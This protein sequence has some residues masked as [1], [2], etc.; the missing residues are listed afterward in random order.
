MKIII[1]TLTLFIFL[2][3]SAQHLSAEDRQNFNPRFEVFELPGDIFGNSVQGM[4]QDKTGFLWFATQAGLHRYD[5]QNFVTYRHDG[6][7]PNSLSADYI[8]SIFL[9]SKGV[10][11]LTHWQSGALTAFDPER[12]I[13][14]RYQHNPDDPGSLSG[15]VLSTVAEDHEGYIWIGGEL[16][17]NRYDPETG[18]F[19]RFQYDPENPK[20]LSYNRVRALYV[21]KTGTLWVGTGFPWD[22]DSSKGGLNRYN[23]E[24]GTFTRYLHDPED[25]TT[26]INNKVRAILEDSRGNFWVGTAGDGLHLMDREKGTF[27]RLTS[28]PLNPDKISGPW[29]PGPTPALTDSTTHITSIFEDGEGRIWIT[30]FPGGLKIFDPVSGIIRHF[31][32][33]S[34][35]D[36]LSTDF[37]WLTYQTSDGTLWIT[38][39][40]DGQTVFKV[41]QYDELFPFFD[42]PLSEDNV[43]S[44]G[45]VKDRAGNIWIARDAFIEHID[46]VTGSRKVITPGKPQQPAS[47]IFGLILDREGY[48]WAGTF[49]GQFCGDPETSDFQL[50]KPPGISDEI[51]Q[52][53]WSPFLHSSSGHFWFGSW[54]NGLFRYDPVTDEV[55]NYA[56]DPNDP[57]SLGGM[58]VGSIYEDEKGNIWVGGGSPHGD[59]S[60]PLFLDRINLQS[61]RIERFFDANKQAGMVSDITEDNDGNLWFIDWLHGFKMLNPATGI[62]KSFT[63]YNSLL[64]SNYLLSL[65]NSGDG[66]LWLSDQS[67]IIEFDPATEIMSVFNQNRGIRNAWDHFKSGFVADDGEVFFS[68]RGGFHAF[69]PD[70]ILQQRNTSLP[71]IRITGFQMLGDQNPSAAFEL[72][73]KP[74]WQTTAVRLAHDQNLFT[75]SVACFD[76]Y[77]ASSN[78]LQF[79]LEGYDKAWRN[80]IRDGETSPYINVP[81]G[82]YTFRVRG[83]NSF[84]VWNMEGASLGITILPPWWKSWWAYAFYLLVLI[85]GIWWIHKYQKERT[86]RKEREKSRDR[87]LEQARKIEKAYTELKTTQAQLIQAEK[88]ASLGELTA[89]IAHEI[90][91]PLNFVNNFS[92][93]NAELLQELKEELDN[94]NLEEVKAITDDLTENEGKIN[95]HGKRADAI[96]KGMLQHSCASA[97]QKEP[98]DINALADEYLRLSYH[99]LRAKDKSFNADFKTEF[100]PNLLKVEVIPQDIGRVLLNL[101]NNAFYAVSEKQKTLTGLK[102]DFKPTVTITTKNLGDRIEISV[103]DNGPGIPDEIKNKIFQPFFT[104][105]KGTEGTGL[106][107]SI[108]HDIVKAH[109]GNLNIKSKVG[110]GTEFIVIIPL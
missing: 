88:M 77:D 103:K 15:S 90:Q 26:L 95:H 79:M 66:K 62:F 67:S 50:F 93:L 20:S 58:M 87:E 54:E 105:K 92:E 86:I 9:D 72:F 85:F 8:E 52:A 5:G 74:V 91:N 82:D 39:G 47:R 84:G 35:A 29:Q 3:L 49:G 4:V 7:N 65:V 81:P 28:N 60:N 107:L 46:R 71:D 6:N 110:E 104:T 48:L 83:A 10:L 57:N 59:I 18:T 27:K 56:H 94:G 11:W 22:T 16:G 97:G 41:K 14:N 102:D 96:V 101:I 30:A 69:Y 98:T 68:R 13:F 75:L 33:G 23:P 100:D 42:I 36:E 108:T 73:E 38:S 64:P 34:S 89:G 109:G 21:D 80:D 43:R 76:F 99:G 45:I 24:D 78:Q 63:P 17:L 70:Q 1:A 32:M 40:G 44:H 25:S 19:K 106:G 51:L 53:F 61:N 31:K 12:Q 55:V 37:L 2:Q